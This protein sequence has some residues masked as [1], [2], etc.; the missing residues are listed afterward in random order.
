MKFLLFCGAGN[1]LSGFEIQT[2]FSDSTEFKNNVYI[3]TFKSE[4]EAKKAVSQLGSAIKMAVL[5]DGVTCTPKSIA[6]Q[7]THKNF[8]TT[9]VSA[10]KERLDSREIKDLLAKGRFL[11]AQDSYGLSP[12]IIAKHKVD[13][14]FLD[15]DTNQVWQT[16][17]VHDFKHW[18]KKD[19]FMPFVNAKAGMLPPKIA[20]SMINLAPSDSWGNGKV[21]V[22]P[23]CGSG[24]VVIEGLELGFNSYGTDVSASQSQEA[25]ENLAHMGYSKQLIECLDSTHLSKK[26]KNKVDLI[27]TEPFMGKTNL[28]PDKIQYLVPGLKKL[29]LGC[30]KDWLSCLK[31]KGV[32]VMVFPVFNDGKK[33]YKTSDIIDDKLKLSYNQLN[34]G[35]LYSRPDAY[36]RREIIVLQKIN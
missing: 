11:D 21:L 1:S 18:I 2:R 17:W 29:Y 23:F 20:R 31:S 12:I 10:G 24:R 35:I 7:I 6:K 25:S 4:D 27:V 3:L 8:S 34:Q 5:L 33:D 9:T 30:L 19:R 16:I 36:V 32:V 22:D 13:E 28:R 15:F 14:F 26:F